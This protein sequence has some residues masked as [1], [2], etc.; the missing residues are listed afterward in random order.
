[1]ATNHTTVALQRLLDQ[2]QGLPNWEALLGAIAEQAQNLE[3]VGEQLATL[4]SIADSVG[5]QLDNIGDLIGEPRQGFSDAVY[6][7]H[8]TARVFL[9]KGS[10]TIPEILRMFATI[11]EAP[12]GL[13]LVE[14]FP[15]AFELHTED[16]VAVPNDTAGYLARFL[17]EARAA[18][19]ASRFFWSAVAPELA[20][21]FEDSDGLGFDDG[22]FIGV[23]DT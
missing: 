15:A 14:R 16:A 8:L 22:E 23:R 19:V 3:T 4:P 1:M 20:F 18:G 6:R 9:N 11:L 13:R 21:G 2:F 10:G 12:E 5:A 7:L 17:T